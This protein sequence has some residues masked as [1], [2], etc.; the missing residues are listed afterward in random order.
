MGVVRPDWWCYPEHCQNGHEWGP[1]LIIVSWS[2]CDC[3][4]AVAT[5]GGGASGHLPVYCAAAPGCR[6]VW[7]RPRC[8]RRLAA[9][10]SAARAPVTSGRVAERGKR[11]GGAPAHAAAAR[12][13]GAA[14]S[15]RCHGPAVPATALVLP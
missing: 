4:P 8:E 14:S 9:M 2:L 15:A 3:A 12:A 5:S 10:A 11:D 1:G 6:S 7:Y 13:A